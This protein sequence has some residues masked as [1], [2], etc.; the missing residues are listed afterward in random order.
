MEKASHLTALTKATCMTHDDFRERLAHAA[1]IAA[2]RS[3]L[4]AKADAGYLQDAIEA[5]RRFQIAA[6]T[7]ADA[8]SIADEYLFG[9]K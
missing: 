5:S 4:L 7:V 9:A 1:A 2:A 8:L 3:G 6:D